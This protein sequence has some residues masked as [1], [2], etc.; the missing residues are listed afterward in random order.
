MRSHRS[1]RSQAVESSD[2]GEAP[3][4]QK[5]TRRKS[6]GARRKSDTD[7]GSSRPSSRTSRQRSDSTA[8]VGASEKEKE[9][10]KENEKEKDKSSVRLSVAG[11]A[12]SALDTMTGRG[13]KDKENFAT[14]EDGDS[15][16]IGEEKS[17][18]TRPPLPRRQS[19]KSQPTSRRNTPTSSPSATFR[20]LR[21][22][23]GSSPSTPKM[24]RAINDFSGATDELSF[25]VGDEIVLLNEV[26]EGWWMGELRGKKGLFP[27]SHTEPIHHPSSPAKLQ[28]LPS[29]KR[30]SDPGSDEDMSKTTLV[31]RDESDVSSHLIA[32]DDDDH[33]FSDSNYLATRT[34]IAPSYPSSY[35]SHHPP[36]S[37]TEDENENGYNP[38]LKHDSYVDIHAENEQPPLA[39]KP[40]FGRKPPPPPPPPRRNLAPGLT[41]PPIPQRNRASSS[42]SSLNLPTGSSPFDSPIRSTFSVNNISAG[43]NP[44]DKK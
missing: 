43:T 22:L 24:V 26:I 31:S 42:I 12:S 4:P 14:L 5:L 33:P 2:E 1:P 40:S 13:K 37:A 16:I 35:T 27:T 44:F 39:R 8:T 38:L 21:A 7:K 15:G 20:S 11:W 25:R 3:A 17:S 36:D 32:S 41:P 28:R 34:A 10:E 6:A 9:K 18:T 29:W 19:S 23:T 30:G